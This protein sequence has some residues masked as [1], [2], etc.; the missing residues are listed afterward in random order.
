M[1]INVGYDAVRGMTF[2]RMSRDL[3]RDTGNMNDPV[4]M[5]TEV[6]IPIMSL[7]GDDFLYTYACNNKLIP[8]EDASVTFYIV[9]GEDT[10]RKPK[11]LAYYNKNENRR[12][13][14]SLNT[15]DISAIKKQL[16][17]SGG[18]DIQKL[19]LWYRES[20]KGYIE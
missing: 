19:L 15:D 5:V 16:E 1:N 9:D 4:V 20:L 10:V 18:I 11:W 17:T 12:A 2:R 13:A 7:K 8:I 14:Y 6:E 3:A